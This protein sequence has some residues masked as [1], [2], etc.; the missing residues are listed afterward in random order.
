MKKLIAVGVACLLLGASTSYAGTIYAC[1]KKI[2]GTI[3]IVGASTLC[4]STEIKMSWP[5]TTETKHIKTLLNARTS[6][7]TSITMG[8]SQWVEDDSNDVGISLSHYQ[9]EVTVNAGRPGYGYILATPT[10][11]SMFYG[12]SVML[13]GARLCVLDANEANYIAMTNLV[14]YDAVGSDVGGKM[15]LTPHNMPGCYDV[16]LDNAFELRAGDVV[17]LCVGTDNTETG[18]VRLGGTTLYFQMP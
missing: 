8:P 4:A 7:D 5:N 13:V 3:R 11:P 9:G 18:V 16:T 14:V 15:D 17:S 6:G 10:V 12:R 1:R 2:G